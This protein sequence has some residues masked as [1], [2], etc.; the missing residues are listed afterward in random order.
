MQTIE[1]GR[2]S[3][4]EC[5]CCGTL[6]TTVWGYL[7]VRNA[8]RAA[9]FVRWS[10][11][12]PERGATF[13]FSIG[14]WG[15]ATAPDDRVA[16]ELACRTIGDQPQFMVVDATTTPLNDSGFLGRNLKRNEV[17]GT[18]LALEVFGMVDQVLAEDP[19]LTFYVPTESR[20]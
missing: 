13:V 9:Y 15:D 7:Q 5:D 20:S 12:H 6:T 19:R 17:I 16:V 8:A 4:Q 1:L 2:T 18:E 14:R 11:G 3:Q 10:E